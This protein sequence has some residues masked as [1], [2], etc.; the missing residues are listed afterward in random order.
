MATNKS[1]Y[2][3]NPLLK[4]VG[5]KVNYTQEQFDEYVKCARDPIYFS[6]YIKII[7]LDEGLVPFEMYDFQQDMIRTFHNNRFVITKCP[8][9]V[10]KTTTAVA[11]LLWTILFQD[12]QSIAVLANRGNTARSPNFK[13]WDQWLVLLADSALRLGNVAAVPRRRRVQ[14]A[15]V[16]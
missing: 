3:D 5:V 15:M 1:S 11:Y 8:R 9:Q 4:R 12:S 16:Q 13:L 6:K 14:T 2:R 7:T 10:G